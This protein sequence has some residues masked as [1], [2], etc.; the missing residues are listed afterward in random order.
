MNLFSR[1][2]KNVKKNIK[3]DNFVQNEKTMSSFI[4]DKV[5]YVKAAGLMYGIESAKRDKHRWFLENVRKEFEHVYALNVI[6]VNE[7][8]SEDTLPDENKY[9]AEFE[10]MRK[11]GVLIGND[12]YASKDGIIYEQ[13]ADVMSLRDLRIRLW[14]FFRSVLYQIE[15][16]AAHRMAAAWFFTCTSKLYENDLYAVE[17]WHGEVELENKLSKAA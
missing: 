6:S 4:V 17:G 5:E 8:Y 7:Q 1:C 3:T 11:M 13:V 12:G 9:D 15:N 10:A 16:K 14:Y 2:I